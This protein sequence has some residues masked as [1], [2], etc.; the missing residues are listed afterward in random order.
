M[1]RTP[2]RYVLRSAVSGVDLVQPAPGVTSAG[3]QDDVGV[4]GGEF[5]DLRQDAGAHPA[6]VR[7]HVGEHAP[8]DAV[9]HP[10]PLVSGSVAEP[11]GE[12]PPHRAPGVATSI[13]TTVS[14]ASSL[15]CNVEL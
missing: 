10:V 6:P 4:A 7:G 11:A 12:D 9:V 8:V 15:V 1:P 3:E 13:S 5:V 14:Q 2:A